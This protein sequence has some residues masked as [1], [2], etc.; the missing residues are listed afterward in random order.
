MTF[1]LTIIATLI[2]FNMCGL[3]A[4]STKLEIMIKNQVEIIRVL[5]NK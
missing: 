2:F 3:A 1:I 5:K 4:I